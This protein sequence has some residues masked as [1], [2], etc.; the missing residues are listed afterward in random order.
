M[1]E[2]RGG[3]PRPLVTLLKELPGDRPAFTDEHRTLTFGEVLESS[4]RLATGLGIA[5]GDR[6][7]VHV[8][9][10]VE[11]AEYCLAVLRA[12]GIGVPA[13]VRSTTAELTRLV[14]DSGAGLLVTEERHAATVRE[15]QAE[16][17][18]LRVVFV[19]DEP[20]PARGE[21]RDDL[22]LD[23]PAWLLYTSGTTG[24]PKEVLTTQRAVLWSSAVCYGPMYGI[25]GTD[26]VL[27]PLPLHHAYALS[28]AFA[29]TIALGTH[30]RIVGRDLP[31][32]LTA[33]P[34]G[35]LAGVPAT[36]LNLRQEIRHPLPAPRLCLSGGSPCTPSARAA[37]RELFGIPVL[38]GYGST[39]TSGK[40]AAQ[41]PGE[42]DL[43]PLPGMEIRVV[44]GQIEVRGPGV[45]PSAAG[46]GGWYRTG[47]AGR[48]ADGRLTIDGRVDDVIVCGGQNVHPTEIEAVI[49]EF[50]EVDDVLVTG[51]PD[52]VLGAV[53]VAFLVSGPTEPDL[54]EVRRLCRERL[55]PFKVPVAFHRIERLPRTTSGKALRRAL[56]VPRPGDGEALVREALAELGDEDLGEQWRE[57]PFAELGLTSVGGVQLRHRLAGA[58]GFDLPQSLVYDFPTPA[59]VI[60]ELDRLL[61]GESRPART[62][63]VSARAGEPIAI[64]ATACRFPGG[65]T[66]PEELWNLVAGG[67]DA[68][69]DFPSDRGWDVAALY[70]PDPGR[71][72]GSTTRRGGFLYDAADFDPALFGM[73]PRDALATDPQQRLLLETSWELFERAGLDTAEVRGSD[74]GVFVGVMHEDYASRL[75]GHQLE[76]RLGIGSS[77]ALASGRISYT[78]GLTGPAITVDTACSSSLVALHWAV[79]ALRAG[80]CSLAVAGGSTVMST[81]RTFLEF[82]RQRGLSP[83]GRC[84]SYAAG[85]NGTAWAEGA[86]VVLLE[87]LSDA[88]RNGHPVLAL[89]SGSAVN[90][91]GASNGLT[92]PSGRAQ[93]AV[94]ASALADAGLAATD[95]DAVEGHGTA[96]PI[97]DP[98]E[99][100]ALIAAY[101][102]GRDRPLWLGSVKANIGHTQAAAGVAGV[103]KMV[104]ALRHE[105]LPRSLHADDPSPRIDWSAGDV[106]LLAEAR[107]WRAGPKPRHAGIS[108]FGIGGTNAHVL[109]SE[110]PPPAETAR[111][112]PLA[113]PWLV[114][115]ADDGALRA[116]ASRLLATAS[117]RDE[118]DVAFTLATRTS[119]EHRAMVPSGDLDALRAL[120]TGGRRGRTV[121]APAT[122]ACL[123][124]G[125]GAQR[126]GMGKELSDGF[127][128]FRS[129][130]DA[131]CQALGGP[132]RDVAFDGGELLNRTDHAQAAL[133]A[134]EVALYRL[135]ESWGVRPGVVTG[136]SIGEIAAAHVAGVLS[137]EDAG[138]LVSARGRLM[139]ALPPG[140]VM[141]AVRAA[142]DEVAPLVGEFA[143][144]VA[145]AAV[146]GPRSLVLSG[147]E[148]VT[149]AIAAQW[150]GSTRLRV[151][152]AF[153]S[154]L[155]DP[156]L[157]EFREVAAG[158]THRSPE[159]VLVSG[160]TGR[161][162]TGI[163][164][165]HW[166]RHARDTVR[167]ADAL[168]A[169]AAAGTGICLEIG[170]SAVLS[171]AA[172]AVLPTVSTM[173]TARG[174]LEAVGELH[175]AGVPV[176]WR[177][178]FD[179]RLVSLPTYP[180]QRERFWL[181]PRPRRSPEG[182]GHAML[183]PALVAPDS[184]R[185]VH[186]GSTGVHTHGW[187]ADHV[188]GD[189]TL[190]P[191]SAFVEI[192]LHAGKA[193]VAELTIEAPLL[194]TEDVALQVVVDGPRIDIYAKDADDWTRHATGRL[195]P[196][197]VFAQPWK[198]DWPPPAI[199]P[200]SLGE[201]YAAREYGPA[202]RAVTGLWQDGDEL[203]ADV[204]L[205]EGVDGRF[206]IHPVLLDAAVHTLALAEAP[207]AEVRVPFLWSGVHLFA[208]AARRA[209]VHC[210][211][212]GPGEAR[213][214]LFDSTG[215]PV[216]IVE[217]L[218]T[219]PLPAG[220][221]MLYRPRW[222]PVPAARA[223]D[224]RIVEGGDVRTVLTALQDTLPR[225]ERTVVVT[226]GATDPAAAAVFGLCTAAS[227]EYRGLITVVDAEVPVTEVRELVGG[228]PEPQLAIRDGVPHALRIARTAPAST[229]PIDPAGTVLITG[230]TGALGA[231]LARHLV[232]AHG[233]RHLLLVSRRGLAAPGAEELLSLPADVRIVGGDIAD[234]GFVQRLVDTCDPPLTAVVHAAAVVADAAFTA[235]TTAGLDTV[236]RP[237]ADAARIL[238]EATR[239]L[240]L[241]AFVLFSSLAGIFGNA[242]QANYAA[243]NRCL[244]AL[245]VLRR[246]EGLPATSIA[247]GLWDLEIGLGSQIP[248]AARHRIQNSGVA[249]LTLEQGLALFD[250]AIGHAEP[251]LIAARLD[252]TAA[253]LPPIADGLARPAPRPAPSPDRRWP[254]HPSEEELRD[255]LRVELA[256]VLGHQTPDTI[257]ED[258]P[259][260]DLGIDS[261]AVVDLRTRLRELTG[262]ELPARVLFE[263][264]TVTE[265]A[266][267]LRE[268]R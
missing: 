58:I 50:P 173:D 18:R 222:V 138:A 263:H 32:A 78:F 182:G 152:H 19:E 113:A 156:I 20:P 116:V 223:D 144:Q 114:S 176:S 198:G 234:P 72:G 106:T 86:G 178:V 45:A 163:G 221:E 16:R 121:R 262:L 96:T 256:E 56:R 129:A 48:F 167:F 194:V 13:S 186:G 112:E 165:E 38:D 161:A 69:G 100:E 66:S 154:P 151:S 40:I 259:F 52:E 239:D 76:G 110:A 261:L 104:E 122:A 132:V 265:L 253:G 39:E 30:T 27:W 92:A 205:P 179:G 123:F 109:V 242:G 127:P 238:H 219:R 164:P 266:G 209:R 80:E 10:R 119:L 237:K 204:A 232:S 120:A 82:S 84:R 268:R 149:E 171:R 155:I 251:V 160:L 146:N 183:G 51:R 31:S 14:A 64:V 9:A 44:D 217:S 55:S 29:G 192:A 210:V 257:P 61:S 102:G 241:S 46:V 224:V 236:F 184:P 250:A 148:S 246:A 158:L 254:D 8:G 207:D 140:G 11:F 25:S 218:L 62:G 111:P 60:G 248:E 3:P 193:S 141:I 118:T 49:A 162:I 83:D 244:D 73:S 252:P 12:G 43:T 147:A 264:P 42:E 220:N 134:F 150:P 89:V 229:R 2:I 233:V 71:I 196:S 108:A 21:P 59:A 153:H 169:V 258:K 159:I 67:V 99:A 172:G 103:I 226:R 17:P 199:K 202:F 34:G 65:V 94:I 95:V 133:F 157:A 47:D 214:E 87:R 105:R 175:T 63:T 24:R 98:I 267:L 142:E 247:W 203:F 36:F 126:A 168:D 54:D 135:L 15:V 201:A 23:E 185:I 166:V 22:G 90:S 216:A 136:H 88:R 81:P 57:R 5:R 70:D 115:A 6:V 35:V 170:P 180:F 227:A 124:S 143:D 91:D 139:A 228:N 85:A 1:T 230:G 131:A 97:G 212:T 130:F 177:S 188:V 137:L 215:M 213:V 211:R 145:I 231:A 28:L 101:G 174:V 26:T 191:A 243:A 235:Q 190:F 37:V 75:E 68:T 260:T 128:V 33:Y 206:G 77:H 195:R 225:G 74:T 208:P 4:G 79:R 200:V 93:R 53:P 245:A 41:L 240:P 107:D 189:S 249:A 197:D 187:L 7:L 117:G 181:D 125:Q 255:L